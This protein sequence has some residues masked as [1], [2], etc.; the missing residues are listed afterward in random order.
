[1]WCKKI[2]RKSPKCWIHLAKEDNLCI[3]P[4]NIHNAGLGLFAYKKPIQQGKN[5]GK[6]TGRNTT[7]GQLDILYPGN[8]QATYALCEGNSRNYRCINANHYRHSTMIH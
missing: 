5:I 7:K 1:M 3:K 4:S 8:E 2:T 6:Y